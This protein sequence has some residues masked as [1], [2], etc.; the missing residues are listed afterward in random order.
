MPA[1]DGHVQVDACG[2]CGGVR[3]FWNSNVGQAAVVYGWLAV[4]GH[5]DDFIAPGEVLQRA[6]YG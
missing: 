1:N 6:R 5:V 2:I 4:A 3:L